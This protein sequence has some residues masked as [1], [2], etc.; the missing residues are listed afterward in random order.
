MRIEAHESE[1][2]IYWVEPEERPLRVARLF[3]RGEASVR[4]EI[5]EVEATEPVLIYQIAGSSQNPS[6]GTNDPA[7]AEQY[8][9]GFF[10]WDGCSEVDLFAHTCSWGEQ[11]ALLGSISVCRATSQRQWNIPAV[12][13]DPEPLVDPRGRVV[14]FDRLTEGKR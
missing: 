8:A 5:L 14:S 12:E 13:D 6:G 1:V 10:K 4:F 9:S 11:A 7:G 3:K 2:W